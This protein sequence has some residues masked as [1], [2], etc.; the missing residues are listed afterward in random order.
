MESTYKAYKVPPALVAKDRLKCQLSV[1]IFSSTGTLISATGMQ[2]PRVIDELFYYTGPLGAVFSDEAITFYFWAPTAQAYVVLFQ[3]VITNS[4]LSSFIICGEETDAHL[5]LQCSYSIWVLEQLLGPLG[6]HAN[7]NQTWTSFLLDID[8][9][10][11]KVQKTIALLAIQ[12]YTCHL[13]RERNTKAH[14]NGISRPSR[15]LQGIKMDLRA[16]LAS[17]TWI[18]PG[19]DY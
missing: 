1:A 8:R 6:V 15:L 16:R 4:L 2:L 19:S 3:Y 11:D 18:R 9:L 5:F 13:W 14:D 7:F 10:H 17:S 12:I